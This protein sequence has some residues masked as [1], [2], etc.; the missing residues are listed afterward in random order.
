MLSEK[1]TVWT[2]L[3]I[4]SCIRPLRIGFKSLHDNHDRLSTAFEK[5]KQDCQKESTF[6]VLILSLLVIISLLFNDT[7]HQL[8]GIHNLKYKSEGQYC[9]YV[10][11]QNENGKT[12]TLPAK[13]RVECDDDRQYYV[14]AVY[15][16]NGG[17]LS[18]YGE[19]PVKINETVSM[20]DEDTEWN[21][22]LLNEH[23]YSPYVSETDNTQVG[24]FILIFVNVIPIIFLALLSFLPLMAEDSDE[25]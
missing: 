10:D 16:A 3:A 17:F 18:F 6:P 9:F 7:L 11:A 25:V 4:L 2:L 1:F 22:T 23:A 8:V 21:I 12:Y 15:F 5:M 14:E 24:D 19:D 20:Y 13:I